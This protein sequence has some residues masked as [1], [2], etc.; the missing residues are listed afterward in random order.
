MRVIHLDKCLFLGTLVL[1]LKLATFQKHFRYSSIE[2]SF[3]EELEAKR[4]IV[5]LSTA[6]VLGLSAVAEPRPGGGFGPGIAGGLISG[7]VIG[8]IASSAYGYGLWLRLWLQL[9]GL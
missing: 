9:S 2:N 3:E 5:V 7:A 1:G 8:G 6:A 4:T